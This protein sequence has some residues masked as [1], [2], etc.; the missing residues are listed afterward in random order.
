[1]TEKNKSSKKGEKYILNKNEIDIDTWS[2]LTPY[3]EIE[4]K[5]KRDI[6]Y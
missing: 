6:I 5:D 1:M 3:I 4:G 2:K